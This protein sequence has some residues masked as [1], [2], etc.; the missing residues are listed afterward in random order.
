MIVCP[1]DVV[2]KRV[3]SSEAKY[4]KVDKNSPF[5]QEVTGDQMPSEHDHFTHVDYLEGTTVV[6]TRGSLGCSGTIKIGTQDPE[7]FSVRGNYTL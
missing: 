2:T 4:E 3:L 5:F 1:K 7:L 6:P